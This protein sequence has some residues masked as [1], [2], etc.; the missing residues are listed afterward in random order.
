MPLSNWDE[1]SAG[2]V[3]KKREV[4]RFQNMQVTH[5]FPHAHS[6]YLEKR[7]S[8]RLHVARRIQIALYPEFFSN[9][10]TQ[11][12]TDQKLSS[13]IFPCWLFVRPS[14]RIGNISTYLNCMMFQ[15]IQTIHDA[16]VVVSGGVWT[17]SDGV[18]WCLEHVWWCL[19]LVW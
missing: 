14:V 12:F 10:E 18:W 6:G 9:C 2:V 1:L 15:T 13:P 7:W 11:R 19:E 8:Q 16:F 17:M 4:N 3:P 5:Q